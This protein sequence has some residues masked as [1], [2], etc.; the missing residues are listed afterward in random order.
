M[1]AAEITT[2]IIVVAAPSLRPLLGIVK[3]PS[4]CRSR[5]NSATRGR[6]IGSR[7]ISSSKYGPNTSG[8]LQEPGMA[9]LGGNQGRNW[10]LP[11]LEFGSS[12]R[13]EIGRLEDNPTG[14]IQEP[15]EAIKLPRIID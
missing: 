1:S 10:G 15:W 9:F 6:Y 14:Q 3:L 2:Q 5:G 7:Y 4:V 11:D 8:S 12:W 13:I